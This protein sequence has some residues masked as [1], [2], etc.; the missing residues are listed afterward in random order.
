M[1]NLVYTSPRGKTI[2]FDDWTEAED[3]GNVPFVWVSMCPSCHNKYRGILGNRCVDGGSGICSV[4]G[5][6]N[7]SEWYV[8]FYD[9]TE[10]VEFNDRIG[11]AIDYIMSH[12][13]DADPVN[14]AANIFCHNRAEYEHLYAV[15]RKPFRNLR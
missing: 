1:K 2:T 7:E 13:Q 11:R 3:F 10:E 6:V 4:K 12:K 5:C 8:D 15:L 9:H 14:D